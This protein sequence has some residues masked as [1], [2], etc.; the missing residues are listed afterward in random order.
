MKIASVNATDTVNKEL[1]TNV[2]KILKVGQVL[3]ATTVDGGEASSK[4][5]LRIGQHLFETRTPVALNNG[6]DLKLLVKMPGDSKSGNLPLLKILTPI[7]KTDFGSI[8]NNLHAID[9][10]TIA[11]DKLR[12]FISVQQSFSLLLQKSL[13][14]LSN[15]TSLE[16]LPQSLNVWLNKVQDNLLLNSNGMN[17]AQLKQKVL[18]SGVFLEAKLRNQ[19]SPSMTPEEVSNLQR[20]LSNDL[21]YQLLA[22]KLELNKFNGVIPQDA[23]VSNHSSES[24]ASQVL[25]KLQFEI[26]NIGNNTLE[27]SNKLFAKL[28]I[29][30]ISK[31]IILLSGP[32]ESVSAV[33]D[34]QI[35]TQQL[36]KLTEQQ[37]QV[38]HK[39]Q[40]LLEQLQYRSMLHE[41]GHH[42]EQSIHKLNSLQ[43]QPL[44]R[45][46]DSL[47][48]LFFNLVFK[49]NNQQ[50]DINFRIQ[51]Q[52]EKSEKDKESWKVTLDFNFKTLGSVQ[53]KIFITDNKVS[54][55]FYAEHSKTADKIKR[56]L[57]LLET[58]LVDAGLYVNNISVTTGHIEDK[59]FV[60]RSVSLLNELA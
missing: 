55:V 36:I 59:P 11:V 5:L 39:Q 28:P 26:M 20:Q 58:G 27:L 54:T 60:N 24:L 37:G 43:L 45:E 51:Q 50:F 12:Q 9:S 32:Q 46:D 41:L 16:Q 17:A 57:P 40:S 8:S 19:L 3:N 31:I 7:L 1:L 6:Q 29:A 2:N 14:L 25:K 53:S 49:G 23:S 48:L 35:L 42:V 33:D 18:N 4:V 38:T 30:L 15:K 34:L 22:I 21:K 44:S 13:A 52:D 47:M 56:L 10:K